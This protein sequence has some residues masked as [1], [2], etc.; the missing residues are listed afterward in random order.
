[1]EEFIDYFNISDVE[2][3][4]LPSVIDTTYVMNNYSDLVRGCNK[5]KSTVSGLEWDIIYS[6]VDIEVFQGNN[7]V[8]LS[9]ILFEIGKSE[10]YLREEF[11]NLVHKLEYLTFDENVV[12]LSGKAYKLKTLAE[13]NIEELIDADEDFAKAKEIFNELIH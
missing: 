4:E 2:E 9:D 3:I 11:K 13:T 1:M 10:D 8:H 6:V 12:S 5:V 7:F